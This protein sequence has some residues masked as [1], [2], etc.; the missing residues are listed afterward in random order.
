MLGPGSATQQS[1]ASRR[2]MAQQETDSTINWPGIA[3]GLSLAILAAYQQFKLPPVLPLL[4][5]HYG[6]GRTL[7]G[8]FMSVYAFCGLL[9]S[10]L[11]GSFMQRRDATV[12]LNLSF[13]LLKIKDILHKPV[14]SLHYC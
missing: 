11:L 10:L 13:L 6:F 9:L 7:A 5:G 12:L 3:Y 14:R 8:G 2:A 1:D 4:I